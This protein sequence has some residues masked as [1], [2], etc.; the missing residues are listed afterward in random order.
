MSGTIGLIIVTDGLIFKLDA[1]NIK[2]FKGEPT[3]NLCGLPTINVYN[4]P[5]ISSSSALTGEYYK[6]CPIRKIT[7]SPTTALHITNL[8]NNSGVG[9][10]HSSGTLY[11]PDK[12]YMA[13]IYIKTNNAL[14]AKTATL[15]FSNTSSNIT[16]WGYDNTSTTQYIE[17]G[18]YRLYTKFY[19][20]QYVLASNYPTY[21]HIVNTSQ[22]ELVTINCPI[23]TARDINYL[24]AIYYNSPSISSN[25]GL[26]GLTIT[27]HGLDSTNWTKLSTTNLKLKADLPFNYYIQL[28][29][30]STL[31]INKT[32]KVRNNYRSYNTA[33]SDSKY[34]KITFDA[35]SINIGDNIEVYWACPMI[36]QKDIDK[37]SFYTTNSRGTTL[38]TG[39]GW[40][41]ISGNRISGELSD[42]SMIF[43]SD[44]NGSIFFDN[45][46]DY[47]N[48]PNDIG[49]TASV[50]VFSW[51][52]CNGD[53]KGGYHIIMG[54][55]QLEMSIPG[56]T[57]KLRIGVCT[58]L[59]SSTRY[60]TEHGS[61]LTN[62]NWHYIGFTFD[63]STK[64]G[65]IDGVDVGSQD[66]ISGNL[67]YSFT[68]RRIGRFGSDATYALNGN[69][70]SI[71]IYD[72][73]LT[74]DEILQNYNTSKSRF[75]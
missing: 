27:N 17:D 22:T 16:G 55:S 65:Y 20:S 29:V 24:Y 70:A 30:P 5:G 40:K 69:I 63:G 10:Y 75:I 56:S 41:D 4:N 47:I 74:S 61:G 23:T 32:I 15:G 2:S 8:C 13:S 64:I 48:L 31:G 62:G 53:P 73:A 33:V 67:I 57:G 21:T 37:P 71:T 36:E 46:D 35:N 7:F 6:G 66:S 68:Y 1:A 60:V 34:W 72:R 28:S 44:D 11:Y 50:S 38:E 52:K 3:T 26:T 42:S 25:G 49:Y 54:G 12:I 14:L 39:G 51:I 45:N 9:A 43:D 59:N 58:D 18:W 19:R